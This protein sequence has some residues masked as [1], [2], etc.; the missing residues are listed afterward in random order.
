MNRRI[1]VLVPEATVP[2]DSIEGL[3]DVE[4]APFK[5]EFDVVVTLRGLGHDVRVLGVHDDLPAVRQAVRE[6]RPHVVFN[7][8][9]EFGGR[10]VG[11]AHLLG[12]LELIRQPYTGC[13]PMGMML[14]FDKA[15]QR[16]ILNFH[17]I[18]SPDFALFRRGGAVR[19]PRRMQFPL[20]VK[21]LTLHGSVGISHASIVHSD[22]KLEERVRFMHEHHQDDVIAE[23]YIEGRELYV[24]ILGN[25]RLETFPI[26]EMQIANLPDGA[27]HIATEKV[28]WDLGYQKRSGV[29]TGPADE[30]PEGLDQRILRMC[31]RAYRALE[32][33]G[34][35]R[36]DL[37]L[38]ADGKVFLIES[39]PNPQLS[40]GEDFAESAEAAGLKYPQLLSR[41]VSLGIR[42]RS[43]WG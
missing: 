31:K 40:F 25:Q 30:L 1:L 18:P 36:M 13:N 2:P 8:L 42:Q 4:V 28:K 5:T 27:P 17:R 3:S 23:E 11:V 24:G 26:W 32:Q 16:K 7:L 6:F 22:E 33:T 12:Y 34:C 37:R 39:N 9:E 41:L 10:G 35:A 19:R 20:I 38:R 21:A 29:T 15:L 14:S 43:T